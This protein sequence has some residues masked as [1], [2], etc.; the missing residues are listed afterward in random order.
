M[1]KLVVET[2]TALMIVT[3]SA[4]IAARMNRQLQLCNGFLV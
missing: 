1:L 3:H 2:G 4:N